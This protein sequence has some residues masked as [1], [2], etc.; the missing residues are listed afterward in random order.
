MRSRMTNCC[1]DR[2]VPRRKFMRRGINQHTSEKICKQEPVRAINF[3]KCLKVPAMIDAYEL[4][5]ARPGF[6]FRALFRAKHRRKPES[7][8]ASSAQTNGICARLARV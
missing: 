6:E 4:E 2:K 3:A 8:H 7:K 1:E 5:Y